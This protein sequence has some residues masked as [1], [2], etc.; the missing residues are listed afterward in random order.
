M[1]E[2]FAEKSRS[3]SQAEHCFDHMQLRKDLSTIFFD[4]M[5]HLPIHLP[6]EAELGG[7]VQYRWI[8]PFERVFKKLK[9]KAKK[10]KDMRSDQ[11]LSL[12]SMARFLIS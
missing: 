3:N 10:I 12:I 2:N 4:V 7:P 5:E 11:L 8:Y 6:Y 1:F 9:G